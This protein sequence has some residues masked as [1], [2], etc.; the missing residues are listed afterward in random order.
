MR[1]FVPNEGNLVLNCLLLNACMLHAPHVTIVV[2][3]CRLYGLRLRAFSRA[4]L[5][6]HRA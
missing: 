3:I 2:C 1:S 5:R 6:Q 4:Q